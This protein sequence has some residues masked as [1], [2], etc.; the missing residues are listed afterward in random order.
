VNDQIGLQW[1]GRNAACDEGQNEMLVRPDRLG[2]ADRWTAVVPGD[3]HVVAL[4]GVVPGA[5]LVTGDRRLREAVASQYSATTPA[6][7]A[8]GLA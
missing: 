5:V 7:F 3:E 1:N 6:K 4:L 8:T 2:E